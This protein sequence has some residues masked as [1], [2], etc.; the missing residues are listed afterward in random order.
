ML[1]FPAKFEPADE[2]GFVVT[3]RDVP[4]A[5]TQGDTLEEA[6]AMAVDALV[7]AMDF[8]FED[9]REVPRPSA[10]QKDERLVELP[11]SVA[12]KVEL[13]N[14]VLKKKARP[15]DIARSMGIKPQEVTRILDLHHATKIDTMAQAFSALG[16]RLELK[17]SKA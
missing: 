1:K 3:F 8:Y 16:Y 5:I 2:G 11:L 4:E 12:S 10:L 14:I 15:I 13:L 7:T 9:G 6:Q 17:V